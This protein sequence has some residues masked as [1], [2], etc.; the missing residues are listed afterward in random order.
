MGK[1]RDELRDR[2]DLAERRLGHMQ[3]NM[4]CIATAVLMLGVMALCGMVLL[5]GLCSAL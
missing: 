3:R 2:I 1:K 5:F 4:D